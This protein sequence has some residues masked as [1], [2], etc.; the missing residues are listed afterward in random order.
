MRANKQNPK[1]NDPVTSTNFSIKK[2]KETYETLCILIAT[3][4][5]YKANTFL[6]QWGG[7]KP[8]YGRPIS[9]PKGVDVMSKRLC[10][11][12][13]GFW[14]EISL[15]H[16]CP[17]LE[18]A[19]RGRDTTEEGNVMGAHHTPGLGDEGGQGICEM[20]LRTRIQPESLHRE[21]V[22]TKPLILF[23]GKD[24]PESVKKDDIGAI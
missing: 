20:H 15:N 17:S 7:F 19:G 5:L 8:P 4:L 23:L 13:E 12:G 18:E 24:S 14:E 16:K 2:D 11:C 10:K 9:V 1:Q 3:K 21:C 6:R 22:P